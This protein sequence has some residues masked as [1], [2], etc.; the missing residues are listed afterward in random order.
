MTAG[1][2]LALGFAV[3]A[4]SAT[5]FAGDK[6]T[7]PWK[8]TG[9]VLVMVDVSEEQPLVFPWTAEHPG[10]AAHLGRFTGRTRGVAD[11]NT[12]INIGV[13]TIV[14]ANGDELYTYFDEVARVTYFTGGSGRFE[15]ATGSSTMTQY[16]PNNFGTGMPRSVTG[17]GRSPS[18]SSVAGSMPWARWMVACRSGIATG[19]STGRAPRSSVTHWAPQWRCCRP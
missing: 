16:D 10:H 13:G 2:A 15:G 14:A 4:L 6:V 17:T 12:G 11:Y 3:C 5:A 19:S 8:E 7:R 1:L 9:K 18:K